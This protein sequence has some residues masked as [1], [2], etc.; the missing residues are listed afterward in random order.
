MPLSDEAYLDQL[1]VGAEPMAEDLFGDADPKAVRRM[2]HWLASGFIKVPK[3]GNLY[4]TTRRNLRS[5]IP[6]STD[7]AA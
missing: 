3:I 6:T 5:Q 1:L 4:V 7:Q 2:R